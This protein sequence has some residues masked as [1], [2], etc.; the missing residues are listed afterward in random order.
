MKSRRRSL[1][2]AL[3]VREWKLEEQAHDLRAAVSDE[4]Q[5]QRALE[6]ARSKVSDGVAA[7]ATLKQRAAFHAA[8]LLHLASYQV[9]VCE[10]ASRRAAE[11]DC[12]TAEAQLWRERVQGTLSERDAFARCL[13]EDGHRQAVERERK[14]VREADETWAL[15]GEYQP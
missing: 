12:A 8:Q 3:R 1:E 13:Q 4:L 6:Q 2:L 5:A 14:Q 9:L 11:L 10:E 15:R 7:Q